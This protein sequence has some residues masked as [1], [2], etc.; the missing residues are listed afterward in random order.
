MSSDFSAS[1]AKIPIWVDSAGRETKVSF[2][3]TPGLK[4]SIERGERPDLMQ[5]VPR[6]VHRVGGFA[7]A[8]H[9]FMAACTIPEDRKTDLVRLLADSAAW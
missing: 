2:R 8:C 7:E 4:R 9:R 5:L 3:V 1:P 6:A